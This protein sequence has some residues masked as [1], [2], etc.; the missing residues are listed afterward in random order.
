LPLAPG[1]LY[2]DEVRFNKV[3]DT[4]APTPECHL[5]GPAAEDRLLGQERPDWSQLLGT[6][7]PV[8]PEVRPKLTLGEVR[9]RLQAD[10]VVRF[11][12]CLT[13]RNSG[14][15]AFPILIV[16]GTWY[17]EV[18]VHADLWD[19]ATGQ[20]NATRAAKASYWGIVGNFPCPLG[21]VIWKTKRR[22]IDQAVRMTLDGLFADQGL[23]P[24]SKQRQ[25]GP[26]PGLATAETIQPEQLGN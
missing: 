3:L 20:L 19:L 2:N 23:S 1:D 9:N 14:G 6:P 13:E 18:T 24:I 17:G 10:Y 25:A 16:I 11:H 12:A 5:L 22:A 8:S 15:N 7:G 21:E 26:E 4:I